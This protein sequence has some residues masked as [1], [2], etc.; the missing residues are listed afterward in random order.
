VPETTKD[1]PGVTK[2]PVES[3]RQTEE[4]NSPD[5]LDTI[6]LQS[7]ADAVLNGTVVDMVTVC[8]GGPAIGDNDIAGNVVT[9]R[10]VFAES[11]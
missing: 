10:V 8:P 1:D 7:P 11:V 4:A 3:I 9:L 2:L 6:L 5:G